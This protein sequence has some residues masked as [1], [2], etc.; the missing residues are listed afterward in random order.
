MFPTAVRFTE[1]VERYDAFL[2]DAYGVLVDA[3]GPCPGAAAA[4][5]AVRAAGKPLL[6]VSNDASR[7]PATAEARFARVGLPIAADEIVLSSG[8]IAADVAEHGLTGA[9]A[10]VLGTPDARAAATAAGLVVVR[11]DDAAPIDLLLVCD[12][13]G[14]EFLAGMNAALTACVRALDAGRALTLVCPNPDLVY[15]RGGGALGFTAG[16]MAMI[17]EAALVR[18]DPGAPRFR[19]LGKPH[20]PIFAEARRRV[21]GATRLLMVGDQLETDIAG[22]RAAGIDAALVTG[23]SRWRV[24]A[25]APDLA[26]HWLL[27][28]L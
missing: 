4:L 20:P 22:A 18:R 1:L 10:M 19:Y 8:L 6:V 7:L 28:W 2:F 3:G 17:L 9:V 12:D 25:T 23:I 16:S 27:D 5:A 13:S 26:P 11:P 24:G 15:P 14:F 21:P